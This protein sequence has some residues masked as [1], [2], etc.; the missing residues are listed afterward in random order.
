MDAVADGSA[1]FGESF[2][3]S[4]HSGRRPAAYA[5]EEGHLALAEMRKCLGPNNGSILTLPWAYWQKGTAAIRNACVQGRNGLHVRLVV[6]NWSQS[7]GAMQQESCAPHEV[8]RLSSLLHLLIR[9]AVETKHAEVE[10]GDA[11][12]RP[13]GE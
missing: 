8:Q 3:S 11:V 1:V 5:R 13:E 7:F 12:E 4:L 10:Q 6:R 2:G 9:E